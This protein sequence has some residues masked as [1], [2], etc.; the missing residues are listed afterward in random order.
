VLKCLWVF[1][2]LP[3]KIL[4]VP[5]FEPRTPRL[6][7]FS[8]DHYTMQLCMRGHAILCMGDFLSYFL[9]FLIHFSLDF[10]NLKS[11]FFMQYWYRWIDLIALSLYFNFSCLYCCFLQR[12]LHPKFRLDWLIPKR[13]WPVSHL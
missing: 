12:Y 2:K 8:H 6:T 11:I 7:V 4:E 5:V 9:V 3:E 1:E 13:L 10:K